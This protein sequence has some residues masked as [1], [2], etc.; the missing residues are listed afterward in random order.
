METRVIRQLFKDS[1]TLQDYL[2]GNT[3]SVAA[4]KRRA[5][6]LE[7]AIDY[8][9]PD[10]VYRNWR[11]GLI[12]DVDELWGVLHA[13]LDTYAKRYLRFWRDQTFADF[14]CF[15]DWQ[16]ELARLSPLPIIAFGL[17]REFG[18]PEP[19]ID[20]VEE[21]ARRHLT[22]FAHTALITPMSQ[23]VD[24][25][26]ARKGLYDTH[27][28]LN[29]ST[30]VDK[31]WQDAL[32]NIDIFV[33][34]LTSAL[35]DG[36]AAPNTPAEM[37]QEL[38]EQLGIRHGAADVANQLHAARRLRL[39]IAQRLFEE[40]WQPCQVS[41]T[42]LLIPL[43]GQRPEE[44][45]DTDL[46]PVEDRFGPNVV[47]G[48]LAQEILFLVLAYRRLDRFKEEWL[49]RALHVYLLVLNTTFV[50][51]CV[52]QAEQFGF[53]QFQ[54]FTFNGVRWLSEVDYT[55]RFHQLARNV[56]SDLAFVEARF[57][58]PADGPALHRTLR[59]ILGGYVQYLRETGVRDIPEGPIDLS[60]H[61]ALNPARMAL[62]LTVHFI[63]DNELAQARQDSGC[64]FGRLRSAIAARWRHLRT[65]VDSLPRVRHYLTGMDA[66]ANELHTPPEV[67]APVYRA[68]RRA[69]FV[70]FTYHVG[71]DFEHLISGIRAVY[72][73]VTF[74]NLREGN[75]IGH[76]TAVGIAPELW[77]SRVPSQLRQR[78][79]D[80][81][82][83]LVFA[84]S[85][86]LKE[87]GAV[88]LITSLEDEI[89]KLSRAIY[90]QELDCHL[91]WT[92]WQL[93]HLDPLRLEDPSAAWWDHPDA[94]SPNRT[95][96]GRPAPPSAFTAP[97]ERHPLWWSPVEDESQEWQLL[98]KA[99][100]ET[101]AAF[102]LFRRYHD[103]DVIERS[104]I[105]EQVSR[106]CLDARLLR[107]LQEYVLTLIVERRVV[108]ETLP[109]SN[110]R[111]SFYKDFSEHHVLRW[112]GLKSNGQQPPVS[113]GT[114]DPGIFASTLR[115]EFMHLYREVR[116]LTTS[117]REAMARLE[118]LN[119]TGRI[120]RFS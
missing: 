119:E 120:Y 79:G 107:W 28:H 17:Y 14:D 36:E 117:D 12:G 108:I 116:K 76:G 61:E 85:L 5:L 1:A 45:S 87:P 97:A 54:K 35:G 104:R 31:I 8:E 83:D 99:A 51:L 4:I 11:D 44:E 16:N 73:A 29:G 34:H 78:R 47:R 86:L 57:A 91:L 66:A 23:P 38:Y 103:P 63:K 13:V 100:Q 74:L 24:D 65:A 81:L 58:P 37:V 50:P 92:A 21:Y 18:A 52:Q 33:S 19:R 101:P 68:A 39:T 72:E 77:C 95:A 112:L 20:R 9:I 26:I 98:L 27:L 25:L 109:T 56:P 82:D 15:G 64:R 59:N 41:L 60:D 48:R 105:Y 53:E 110:V 42:G 10:H 114:D 62:R 70:H 90:G 113:V 115:G 2:G 30:E 32:S 22:Q 89:Q 46:H 94:G 69:G 102:A 7:R 49:A 93:R 106:D 75:R 88:C 111:I 67:F 80:R 96:H 40:P 55:A 84:R 71:E 118:H 3:P 43:G 6:V